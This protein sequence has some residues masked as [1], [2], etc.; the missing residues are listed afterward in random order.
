MSLGVLQQKG[1]V[2]KTIL[3]INLAA[4]FAKKGE[5]VRFV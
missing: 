2:G 4:C 3:S 5:V 1:G